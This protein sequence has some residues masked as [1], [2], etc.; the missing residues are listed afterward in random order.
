MDC[1]VQTRPQ[2]TAPAWVDAG[3]ASTR[4]SVA[5]DAPPTAPRLT[6][7]SVHSAVEGAFRVATAAARNGQVEA[8]RCIGRAARSVALG[9]GSE[10]T[11]VQVG[12]TGRRGWASC[13]RVERALGRDSGR[14]LADRKSVV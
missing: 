3:P 11:V 12:G 5:A 13:D 4:S 6:G 8:E 2:T 14:G 1:I 7:Y 10:R 9:A